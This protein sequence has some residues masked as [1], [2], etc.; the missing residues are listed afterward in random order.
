MLEAIVC[1]IAST[2]LA[3][4]FSKLTRASASLITSWNAVHVSSVYPTL[5]IDLAL[6][7]IAC[8]PSISGF[9]LAWIKLISEAEALLFT[10]LT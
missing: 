4:G 1:F 6:S 5:L 3:P 9:T 8:N 7:I 10:A 2:S